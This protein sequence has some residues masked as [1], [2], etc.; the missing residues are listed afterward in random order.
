MS[1]VIRASAKSA[2]GTGVKGGN[3]ECP[4]MSIIKIKILM[5]KAE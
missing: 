5:F 2:L 4:Q 3:Q 1:R